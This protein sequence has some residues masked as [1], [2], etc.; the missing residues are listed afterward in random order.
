MTAT[1]RLVASGDP[2]L[3]AGLIWCR[4]CDVRMRQR[5]DILSLSGDASGKQQQRVYVCPRN[6]ARDPLPAEA[7]ESTVSLAAER[8]GVLLS[9]IVPAYRQ[10]A[11]RLYLAAV[12]V[13]KQIDDLTYYWCT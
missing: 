7:L 9:A 10:S 5:S 12:H 6:C 11:L 4:T 2:Y 3:L 1:P 13:G 8:R